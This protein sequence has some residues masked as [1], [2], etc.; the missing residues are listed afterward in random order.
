MYILCIYVRQYIT[1]FNNAN[2]KT[3]DICFFEDDMH[4]NNS[5]LETKYVVLAVACICVL[6]F[7]IALY[8]NKGK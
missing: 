7:G 1:L 8:C 4:R 6:I 3:D 5:N 2:G